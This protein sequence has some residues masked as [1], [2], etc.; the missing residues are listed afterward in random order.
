MDIQFDSVFE[1]LRFCGLFLQISV[2]TFT[3]TEIFLSIFVQ[4]RSSVNGAL[5]MIDCLLEK[6]HS[7][8]GFSICFFFAVTDANFCNIFG[9]LAN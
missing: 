1:N 9:L 8:Y 5:G 6:A 2:N 4:K 3:K 7:K